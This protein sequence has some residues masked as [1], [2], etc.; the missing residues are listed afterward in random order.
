ML[1]S[2]TVED[3]NDTFDSR[4]NCNAVINT[5]DDK[6]ILGCRS[7]QIPEGIVTIGTGAFDGQQKL[8]SIILPNSIKEIG[9]Y[10]FI[11]CTGLKHVTLPDSLETIL[12]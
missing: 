8:D 1:T 9:N 2:I 12:N 10:A 7:T 6:L 3:G 5:D 4:S 11:N